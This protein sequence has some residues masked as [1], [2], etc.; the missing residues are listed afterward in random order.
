MPRAGKFI[1]RFT[2]HPQ[3]NLKRAGRIDGVMKAGASGG[4]LGVEIISLILNKNGLFDNY[5]KEKSLFYQSE[6]VSLILILFIKKTLDS[7]IEFVKIVWFNQIFI[8]SCRRR[9]NA[10][11]RTSH[12]GE[13]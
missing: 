13:K 12:R 8:C 10:V 6:S 2:Q 1:L 9:L 3:T 5:F 7:I 11:G 4:C